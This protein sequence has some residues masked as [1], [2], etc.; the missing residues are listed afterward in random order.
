M[1][2]IAFAKSNPD[3]NH[4]LSLMHTLMEYRPQGIYRRLHSIGANH[5]MLHLD[6]L[7]LLYHFAKICSGHVLEI[8]AYV[9]G[10]TIA[11]A[12]GVQDSMSPKKIISIEEG[13]KL[14]HPT[15]GSGNILKDLRKN[16]AKHGLLQMVTLMEGASYHPTIVAQ[17]Q[18]AVGP[19]DIGLLLIDSGGA[20]KTEIAYYQDRLSQDCLVVMDDYYTPGGLEKTSEIR[21]TV[22]SLVADG[23]LTP[24]GFYGY[25][26]WFGRWNRQPRT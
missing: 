6:V 24:L 9:G 7:T 21:A 22:D 26:T 10:A 15:L 14:D 5:S 4:C 13:G 8:G 16:L 3:L 20:L 17:V 23:S 1:T 18:Q 19:Q 12:L 11:M 2:E 25:G